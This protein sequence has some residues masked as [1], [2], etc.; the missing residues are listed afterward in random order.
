MTQKDTFEVRDK[1]HGD[2]LWTHKVILF[3]EFVS[4]P[5]YKVYS[6]LASYA[7][8]HNQKAWPSVN[9]LADKIHLSR[10]T[11]LRSLKRLAELQIIEVEKRKGKSNV[12]S[13]IDVIQ[14]DQKTKKGKP[15]KK[16]GLTPAEKNRQFFDLV[17]ANDLSGAYKLFDKASVWVERLEKLTQ[18]QRAWF[19]YE[20]NK[21][22]RYWTEKNKSGT[23]EKW[24]QEKAFE[25]ERRLATWFDNVKERAAKNQ[26]SR[27]KQIIT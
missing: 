22:V 18:E 16:T 21:F 6:A 7:G 14:I 25:I 4:A 19:D 1:R 26:A 3:S 12:Y 15:N 13:L 23:K 20:I 2:W 17:V 9:T 8:N 27:G 10:A 24:E 11:I 5:D